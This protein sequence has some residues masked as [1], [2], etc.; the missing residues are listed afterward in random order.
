[1]TKVGLDSNGEPVATLTT[2][3]P[4]DVEKVAIY[5]AIAN[6]RPMSRNWRNATA[7]RAAD[8]WRAKLPVLDAGAYL[9]AY[10]N[11]RYKSGVHLSSNEEALVPAS[12]GA[13][14][15]TDTVSNTL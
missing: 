4:A 14:R 11:V 3:R 7:V 12:L 9:F 13:A 15:A 5:Y 1:M 8:G 6:P 2:D 10:A